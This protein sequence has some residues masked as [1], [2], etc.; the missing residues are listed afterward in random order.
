MR[1]LRCRKWKL[2][3]QGPTDVALQ[4]DPTGYKSVFLCFCKVPLLHSGWWQLKSRGDDESGSKESTEEL[5]LTGSKSHSSSKGRR[6]W[7]HVMRAFAE[8]VQLILMKPMGRGGGLVVPV[9]HTEPFP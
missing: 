8:M 9:T 1:K 6:A 2:L 5:F 7:R 3:A 4:P